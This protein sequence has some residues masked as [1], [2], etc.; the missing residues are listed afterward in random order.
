MWEGNVKKNTYTLNNMQIGRGYKYFNMMLRDTR[1]KKKWMTVYILNISARV[2]PLEGTS[3]STPSKMYFP[4]SSCS[5]C[6]C[7][8]WNQ[9]MGRLLISSFPPPHC[10]F[11]YEKYYYLYKGKYYIFVNMETLWNSLHAPLWY[12]FHRL[13]YKESLMLRKIRDITEGWWA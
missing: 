12:Q 1:R 13:D 8:C 10:R 6:C 7:C 11:H 5:W 9:S 4:M 3:F 2:V